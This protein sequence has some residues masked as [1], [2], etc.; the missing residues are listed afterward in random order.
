MNFN[1]YSQDNEISVSSQFKENEGKLTFLPK[2]KKS[3]K[4]LFD[5]IESYIVD[6]ASGFDYNSAEK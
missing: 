1:D 5:N 6:K 2:P 4:K 3:G